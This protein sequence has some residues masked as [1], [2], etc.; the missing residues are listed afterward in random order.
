MI[1]KAI[2]KVNNIT[3]SY[4]IQTTT[5]V[6]IDLNLNVT[7]VHQ[8]IHCFTI[9]KSYASTSIW[10]HSQMLIKHK[11]S[12]WGLESLNLKD[13]W[14]SIQ[15]N[16]ISNIFSYIFA[17]N[18]AYSVQYG[19]LKGKSNLLAVKLNHMFYVH[20][21]LSCVLVLDFIMQV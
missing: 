5:E 20:L 18:I 12:I 10:Y 1:Y 13:N 2:C 15:Q 4:E 8:R 6:T 11:V 7:N 16:S 17:C 9:I 14:P 19:F 21:Q 3:G